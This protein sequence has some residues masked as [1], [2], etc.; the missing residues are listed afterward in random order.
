MVEMTERGCAPR[1]PIL[2]VGG[3][4]CFFGIIHS[5]RADGSAYVLW[6]LQGGARLAALQFC[7]AYLVLAAALLLLSLQR[8]TGQAAARARSD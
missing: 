1:P 7:L 5:V 2:L 4:L 8:R 6:Q 3:A